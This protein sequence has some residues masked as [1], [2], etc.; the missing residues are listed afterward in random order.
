MHLARTFLLPKDC[1]FNLRPGA[2]ISGT[3][4][5]A[6]PASDGAADDHDGCAGCNDRFSANAFWN[7][8]KA[9][10]ER[11]FLPKAFC[12]GGGGGGGGSADFAGPF[13]DDPK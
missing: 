7:A 12:G 4:F 1:R 10:D 8:S 6:S 9:S 11:L 5:A 13:G 2:N 3:M